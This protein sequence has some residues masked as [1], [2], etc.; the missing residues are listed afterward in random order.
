MFLDDLRTNPVRQC[1]KKE[2]G[3]FYFIKKLSFLEISRD[4]ME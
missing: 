3:L 1:V 4:L 2:V